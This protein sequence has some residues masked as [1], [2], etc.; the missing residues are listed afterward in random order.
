MFMYKIKYKK[1]GKHIDP[2]KTYSLVLY[3]YI[4][5]YL[6]IHLSLLAMTDIKFGHLQQ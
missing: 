6:C 5:V 3:T 4:C 2:L 1:N